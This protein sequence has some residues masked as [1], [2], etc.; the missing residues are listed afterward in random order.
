M[1]KLIIGGIILIVLAVLG[2]F[3]FYPKYLEKKEMN[4]INS[5]V[6]MVNEYLLNNKGNLDEIKDSLTKE[7]T[8]GDR[9]DLEKEVNKYLG[10]I[11]NT[12][13]DLNTITNDEKINNS[14]NNVAKDKIEDDIKY[15]NE[16][17]DK[18]TKLQEEIEKIKEKEFPL[19]NEII[20]FSDYEEKID[21]TKKNISNNLKVLEYLKK[22]NN[23]K[24]EEKIIFT[25]RKDYN[26][27][28]KIVEENNITSNY[29]LIPDKEGPV[30]T[31]S[32]ITITKGTKVDIKS[33]V[34]CMD[35]VDDTCE[36][37]IDGKYDI[38]K[39]GSY[40]IKI[41]STDQSKNSTTKNIKLNVKEKSSASKPS[42]SKNK[43]YY[44]EVIRNQNVVIVYGLDSNNQY[45]KIVKV[46][47]CSV[48]LNGKTPT[49][50]FTTSDKS[51]WGWLVGNV[52]GQYYTRITGSILF[53]S[54]P[55]FKKAK[56][57]L[58]WE[59]YNKLGTAASKGCVRLT[60][61]DVKW[62]YDN[63]P[64]GTT[65]KIYDGNL[66]SGVT[67]PSAPKIDASSPNKGWD[68]TDPDKN[69]PWKK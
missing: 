4:L 43:P 2:I 55:Y 60:V 38:N 58:E 20:K 57:Q 39:T 65:V 23:W 44:I 34:K 16:N 5:K 26:E 63:C 47:V 15:L 28:K 14:L 54:V 69:N 27:Y 6:T 22:D 13:S 7:E 41:T 59:E 62:I 19:E 21:N 32:D 66:P 10:N 42:G 30:I 67:K 68:P 31:A 49:G 36:C 46:F 25:K 37:V 8:T 52:Y 40:T 9:L 17:N 51:S 11:L 56:N 61:R 35:L 33:K 50:T 18:L 1:K 45:T 29:G 48:G 64:R 3:V 53:H 12:I 24:N